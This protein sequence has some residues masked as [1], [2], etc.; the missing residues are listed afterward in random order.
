MRIWRLMKYARPYALYTLASV[1]L[2]AVVGAMNGLRIFL[3][4]PIFE[5]VLDPSNQSS[6]FLL[7]RIP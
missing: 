2:M 5:K 7:I 3:L 4:K 6:N 1:V